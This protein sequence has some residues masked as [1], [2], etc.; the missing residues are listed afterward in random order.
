VT[1]TPDAAVKATSSRV[2]LFEESLDHI[3]Q[4]P[5]GVA[6]RSGPRVNYGFHGSSLDNGRSSCLWELNSRS[7]SSRQNRA[8][9]K[10][11][12]ASR[13]ARLGAP[14]LVAPT[15]PFGMVCGGLWTGRICKRPNAGSLPRRGLAAYRP[16]WLGICLK[17]PH[18]GGLRPVSRR[19]GDAIATILN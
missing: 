9:G 2:T 18:G 8:V 4:A 3:R 7:R 5:S 12:V 19:S 14:Y 1:S 11:G 10:S 17:G 6:N 13:T 15:A 16:F